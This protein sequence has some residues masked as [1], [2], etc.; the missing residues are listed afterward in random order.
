[1]PFR[2]CPKCKSS[3]G[4]RHDYQIGGHGFEV[5]NY[6]GETLEAERE[7]ID[8]N[9]SKVSCI[10]CGYRIDADKVKSL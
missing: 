4:F 7:V 8:I 10:E 9:E 6:K 5:R 3:K 2:K 1:M